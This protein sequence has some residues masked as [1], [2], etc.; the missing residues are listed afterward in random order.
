MNEISFA[1]EA[2]SGERISENFTLI[3]PLAPCRVEHREGS[4]ELCAGRVM[5]IPPY[6]KYAVAGKGVVVRFKRALLPSGGAAIIED[7]RSGGIAHAA[8]QAAEYFSSPNPQK[9]ILLDALGELLWAYLTAFNKDVRLSPV[10]ASVRNETLKNISTPYYSA[11]DSIKKL[12]LNYDYVRKLFKKEM[13]VT[14]REYLLSCRMKLAR[15]LIASGTENLHS[16]YSVSQIAEACGFAD[17]LYFSRVFKQYYGFSP[18]EAERHW[19]AAG[20]RE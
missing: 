7:D 3:V 16:N 9:D 15:E 11:K 8:R 1:G 14:P 19:K 18:S 12:P 4:A 20:N 17:P 10:V 5:V 6:A 13:G 2:E